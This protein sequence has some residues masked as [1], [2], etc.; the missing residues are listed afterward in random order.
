MKL[1]KLRQLM[2][3]L[4]LLA[5]TLFGTV[6]CQKDNDEPIRPEVP[7]AKALE[8]QSATQADFNTNLNKLVKLHGNITVSDGKAYFTLKDNFEVELYGEPAVVSALSAEAKAKLATDGQEVTAVGTFTTLTEGNTVKARLVYKAE[9]DL[10]F[11]K[12]TPAETKKLEAEKLTKAVYTQTK[13]ANQTAILHGKVFLKEGVAQFKTAEST[14]FVKITPA[15]GLTL[16]AQDL[17]KLLTE[18]YEVTV[19]GKF[20][21]EGAQA[22]IIFEQAK[23]LVFGAAPAKPAAPAVLSDKSAKASDFTAN[24]GKWVTLDGKIVAKD[25]KAYITFDGVEVALYSPYTDAMF[26]Q[27]LYQLAEGETV[28]VTGK[29]E[30]LTN[31]SKALSYAAEKNVT[32]VS[33]AYLRA[34]TATHDDF[35]KYMN[36]DKADNI[37]VILRGVEKAIMDTQNNHYRTHVFFGDKTDIEIDIPDF[38]SLSKETQDKLNDEKGR[39][40]VGRGRFWGKRGGGPVIKWNKLSIYKESN[41]IIK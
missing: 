12:V 19:T 11:G 34:E 7:I 30:T 29:F 17:E 3:V 40:F 4:S 18:G 36:P 28:S 26:Q 21:D 2:L 10:T 6:S 14:F 13:A 20:K 27:T 35:M 31:G 37:Q 15:Q 22:Q 1:L 8:A 9:K 23:D 25:K 32:F 39:D 38:N 5:L 24:E 16:A 33:I 41:M